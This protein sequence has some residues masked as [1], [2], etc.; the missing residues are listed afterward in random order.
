M[1]SMRV[2]SA[3][4]LLIFLFASCNDGDIIITTFDFDEEN[5][6]GICHNERQKVLY[7]INNDNVH[8]TLTIQ[9]RDNTLSRENR[10]ISGLPEL[11]LPLESNEV[12]PIRI[13]LGGENE[14]IYRTYDGPIPND[15]FCRDV[16]PSSPRVLQEYRS[17]GGEIIISSS[18]QY[19]R[20]GNLLDHDGDGIPSVEEGMATLQDTDG[21]GIPDYLD[22][23]DDGDNVAT[24]TELRV[25]V[26][27]NPTEEGYPD[28]DGDGVP[29]HLDDDDDGDGVPTRREVT[30][31]NQ[32]PDNNVNEGGNLKRYLDRFTTEEY[33]GEITFTI[34]NNIPVGYNSTVEVRNLKLRNQGGDG[35]EISFTEKVLGTFSQ[36]V[37]SSYTIPVIAPGSEGPD[38]DEDEDEDENEEEEDENPD[39]E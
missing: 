23:D 37:N 18:I 8:E 19:S 39:E 3:L 15:Y 36:T 29:N 17:V 24:A 26:G 31:D 1:T 5:F 33:T 2:Y 9:I 20:V 16:P 11:R 14:V 21:D 22:V 38:E 34:A 12:A 6:S 27:D 13:T 25:A 32:D 4:F 35:E 7:H 10:L 28:T 30:E